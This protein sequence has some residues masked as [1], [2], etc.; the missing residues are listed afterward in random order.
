LRIEVTGVFY[1]KAVNLHI[2]N[3]LEKDMLLI[4]LEQILFKKR[5]VVCGIIYCC[6]PQV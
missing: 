6:K 1:I 2:G 4:I 5:P 3:L